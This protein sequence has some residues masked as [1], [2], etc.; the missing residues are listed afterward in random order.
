MNFFDERKKDI[1][2][3]ALMIVIIGLVGCILVGI[4][5]KD[6]SKKNEV[7]LEK[8]E[9][10][11]EATEEVLEEYYVDIK[12]A[13]KKPGV[14]KL[15]KG[16]IVNDV[17]KMAGGLKSN[18]STKYINLSYEIKN[19]DVIYIY[20]NSEVKKA[21]IKEECICP[22]VEIIKCENSSIVTNNSIT[23]NDLG[24]ENETIIEEDKGVVSSLIN[25]NTASLDELLT[26]NGIGESKAL[27]IIEYRK[28]N[29][30][31]KIEDLMN[32]SGIG[33]AL[34]N[35]VKDSITV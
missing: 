21:A 16:S 22:E 13:V 23:N 20:T 5:N 14:Y 3:V 26:L 1:L 18:A 7:I 19:H 4:S 35:K 17:I 8:K 33:E 27:A 25:I 34:Y 32:V 24:I 9:E 28:I 6:N 31:T 29:K 2:I 30:F 12:G 10:V 15:N 11:I